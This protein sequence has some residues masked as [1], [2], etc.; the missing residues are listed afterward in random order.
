MLDRE[1]AVNLVALVA[2]LI[3]EGY[4]DFQLQTSMVC[5]PDEGGINA[6]NGLKRLVQNSGGFLAWDGLTLNH[7][8]PADRGDL[9]RRANSAW[10][11]KVSAFNDHQ[12]PVLQAPIPIN[13]E[14]LAPTP[15]RRALSHVERPDPVD[16][17]E[18]VT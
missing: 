1:T 3:S 15:K 9:G 16:A 4:L 18:T 14:T 13:P 12:R 7:P 5:V 10:H 6:L 8:F 17:T 11:A 2:E